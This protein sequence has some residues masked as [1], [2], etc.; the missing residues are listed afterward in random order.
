MFQV[1]SFDS[2]SQQITRPLW[3]CKS[4]RSNGD[5]P[6]D[7]K[8]RHLSFIPPIFFISY[9]FITAIIM[10]NVVLAIL[11][12]QFLAASKEFDQA[13]DGVGDA[14]A[15]VKIEDIQEACD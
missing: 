7:I 14:N 9:V 10:S 12:D 3:Y 2:W 8:C 11:L 5:L 1:M 6:S 13:E 15:D 4:F